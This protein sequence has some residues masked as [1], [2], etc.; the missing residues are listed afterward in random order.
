MGSQDGR[1]EA[2]VIAIDGSEAKVEPPDSCK[3]G[4]SLYTAKVNHLMASVRAYTSLLQLKYKIT[5]RILL[6]AKGIYK[7]SWLFSNR[8]DFIRR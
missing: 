3:K 8:C 4:P 7:N 1:V 5:N 2:L 6:P